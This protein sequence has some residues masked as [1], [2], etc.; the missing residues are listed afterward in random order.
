M[1][2]VFR[3]RFSKASP[4]R[5][6]IGFTRYRNTVAFSLAKRHRAY[7]FSHYNIKGWDVHSSIDQASGKSLADVFSQGWHN[8]Y[9][10]MG[11]SC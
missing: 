8:L 9:F 5:R 7:S 4:E 11:S 10:E 1:G 6:P 3:V 2:H